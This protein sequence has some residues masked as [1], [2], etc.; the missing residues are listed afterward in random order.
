MSKKKKQSWEIV[1]KDRFLTNE[2]PDNPYITALLYFVVFFLSF[3][4]IFVCFFQLCEI[5]GTSMESTLTNGE[6]VLLLKN[7]KS[8]KRGD[9]VVITKKVQNEN[10]QEVDTNIIKRVIAV[11]GDI[12]RFDLEKGENDVE[13][14]NLYLKVKGSDTFVLQNENYVTE[15]MIKNNCFN[16]DFEF[17]S[18]MEIPENCVFVMGD[19]RNKSNDSRNESGINKYYPLTS[20]YG[21]AVLTIPKDSVLEY[22]LKLL[23]RENNSAYD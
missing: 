20:I 12:L 16:S 15:R 23:Y 18:E 5:S 17:S 4:L 11:E 7:T 8:F 9:I 19:N 10:G 3:L 2:K 6:H 13:Y 22:L 1:L 14:V 21:K